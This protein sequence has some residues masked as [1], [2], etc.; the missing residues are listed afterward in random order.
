M[1]RTSTTTRR[2]TVRA[3]RALTAAGLAGVGVVPADVPDSV[4]AQTQL[5]L[6]SSDAAAP[7]EGATGAAPVALPVPFT[8][9]VVASGAASPVHVPVLLPWRGAARGGGERVTRIELA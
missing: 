2:R 5:R 6:T 8:T 7:A 4:V 1:S 9:G 3:V